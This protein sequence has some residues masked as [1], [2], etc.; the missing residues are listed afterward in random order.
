MADKLGAVLRHIHKMAGTDVT[1]ELTDRELVE[2]FTVRREEAAF[3]AIVQRHGR[4]VWNVC[5]HLLNH[6]QDAEDAMQAT[7]LVLARRAGAIRKPEALA[8]WLHGVARRIAL[9]ARRQ[10]AR[11]WALEV[12]GMQKSSSEVSSEA[13]WHDLQAVLD[14]EIQRLPESQRAPFVL[15]FLE[16]RS[17]SEAAQELG[18]KEGTVS[19]RLAR[20]RHRLQQRLT[21]RGVTLSAAL[22]AAALAD[23]TCAALAALPVKQLCKVAFQSKMIGTEG[24]SPG[25]ALLAEKVINTKFLSG[26]SIGAFLALA[27][28]LIGAWAG[29][30]TPPSRRAELS[31]PASQPK[32]KVA[33]QSQPAK[34]ESKPLDRLGD[35]LPTGALARLGT[36][37]FRHGGS[38]ICG[39]FSPSGK[40][41]AT[42]GHDKAI[43]L[44]D[45]ATGKERLRLTGHETGVESVAF[46]ADGKWLASGG[47]GPYGKGGEACMIRVWDLATGKQVAGFCRGGCTVQSLAFSR[48]RKIVASVF[49]D[50]CIRLWDIATA[51]MLRQLPGRGAH[52]DAALSPDAQLA[53]WAYPDKT[54]SIR[55]LATGREAHRLTG[56]GAGITA[57]AFAPDAK[58]LAAGG[59]DRCV[60]LFSLIT[61]QQVGRLAGPE[62]PIEK[63]AFLPGGKKLATW[64][65]T[66]LIRLWGL[67]Q[68]KPLRAVRKSFH[69]VAFAADGTT[70]A[71]LG[72]QPAAELWN[73]ETDRPVRQ[74]AAHAAGLNS[75]TLL[76]DGKTL[77]TYSPADRSLRR[78]NM[79]TGA[80]LGHLKVA[81]T[82][83]YVLAVAV[84]G[85]GKSMAAGGYTYGKA[86]GIQ[87]LLFLAD[88]ATGRRLHSLPGHR[89]T[90]RAL[91]LSPD[92]KT[93]ASAGDG[94]NIY[95]WDVA[96]GKE[97]CHSEGPKG[98]IGALA[99]SP[100][101]KV[102][103]SVGNGP[104]DRSLR[105]WDAVTG[106]LIHRI[107]RGHCDISSLHF[108][109]DGRTVAVA[110]GERALELWE[111]ATGQKR[112]TFA[113]QDGW[114]IHCVAFSPNGQFLAV[115]NDNHV[116]LWDIWTGTEVIRFPGHRGIVHSLVFS[117]DGKKLISASED[118][119]GLV[120]DVS[121]VRR[122]QPKNRKLKSGDLGTRWLDLAAADAGVAHQAM[123]S[124]IG[125]PRQAVP[126]LG[127]RLQ[128][129]PALN[130]QKKKEVGHWIDEL[131]NDRF[132]T[133]E[134]AAR[135]LEALGEAVCPALRQAL[136]GRLSPEARR[137]VQN[138]IARLDPLP[139]TRGLR[140]SRAIEVLE[141]IGTA[142]A[143]A[144]LQKVAEGPPESLLTQQAKAVLERTGPQSFSRR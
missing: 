40:I 126:F 54:I 18:W 52:V 17:R 97:R 15:C 57:L 33:R 25:A 11:R 21:A 1:R 127:R 93:L 84:T 86:A 104:N 71:T 95:L 26:L 109:P 16:G 114:W 55:V 68:R 85:D 10:R 142:E 80:E 63:V 117:A 89:S 6:Q 141:Q 66:G 51:K 77:A 118:T 87:P 144:V 30:G 37:R 34:K 106:K 56:L 29:A 19:S 101:G 42:A 81:K 94:G 91:A 99:F 12:M 123:V 88:A 36:I 41:L 22:G 119:T 67:A 73:V 110:S 3:D 31:R 72:W 39:A 69:T 43:A 130:L 115:G 76:G 139:S 28:G 113:K 23:T 132:A 134:K 59:A 135:N 27:L 2:R 47:G 83:E 13:V 79:S 20:A 82:G 131:D 38:I 111:V 90:V 45:V 60:R 125:A 24:I 74:L 64:N 46:S 32:A 5:R 105:L 92:G 44:W 121:A 100:D 50:R 58:T 108:S 136:A 98:A 103:G 107:K 7:F 128:P 75:V 61:G 122:A 116:G 4:L 133:R 129:I 65:D 9:T 143:S 124:L 70:M 48:D 62:D 138:L 112:I 14:E 137:R 102:L 8:S 140:L 78:W 120:W 53:A 96:T 49:A 35:P